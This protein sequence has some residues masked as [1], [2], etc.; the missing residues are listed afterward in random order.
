[1]P[2][3]RPKT[4]GFIDWRGSKAR[5]IIL[6]DLELGGYLVDKDNVTAEDLFIWYKKMPEF[7]DVIFKQFK[8]RL[9]DHRKQARTKGFIDWRSSKAR[10]IILRDL[11]PGGY[12]VEMNHVSAEDL[13][14]WY[15]KMPEF[16][17]VVLR[18]FKDRLGD[19]RKQSAQNNE[20][21]RRDEEACQNDRKLFPRKANNPRNDLLC[22]D[23]HPAKHLLRMDI[24]QGVHNHLSPA[25][26]QLKRPAYGQ[27]KYRIFKDRIY[28]EERRTKFLNFLAE[29]REKERP[30]PSLSRPKEDLEAHVLLRKSTPRVAPHG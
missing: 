12:L 18:Q 21:A 10:G 17:E 14:D 24:A 7:E 11:E 20:I 9:A 16:E 13:F 22:F 15:K 8:A 25:E 4:T 2:T 29:K 26:F 27:F 5:A 30:T 6:R 28:Q 19:H 23:L 3:Q 1:M